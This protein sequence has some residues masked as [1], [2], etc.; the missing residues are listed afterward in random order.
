MRLAA[1]TLTCCIVAVTAMTSNLG[2]SS[3]S[4]T[5]GDS[6]ELRWS[7]VSDEHYPLSLQA[8]F[9]NETGDGVFS[10]RSTIANGLT[11]DRFSWENVPAPLD[12]IPNAKYELILVPEGEN[13]PRVGYDGL[14]RVVEAEESDDDS[15]S[16]KSP[17]EDAGPRSGEDDYDGD[18]KR[19]IAI[20]TG[21]GLG[22][23]LP[24]VL[25]AVWWLKRRRKSITGRR[26][27]DSEK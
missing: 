22:L 12:H 7:G 5:R 19:K 25:G 6:V 2:L 20:G 4:L 1:A 16:G 13:G 9:F 11:R 18:A 15:S 14:F 8:R 23:G 27:R 10:I 21:V 3:R 17:T 26:K 24:L